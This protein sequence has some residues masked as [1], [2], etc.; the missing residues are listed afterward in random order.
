M[1]IAKKELNIPSLFLLFL[2]FFPL[3]KASVNVIGMG[4]EEITGAWYILLFIIS[5]QLF[6]INYLT[7]LFCE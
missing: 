1:K 3:E 6:T 4:Q 7:I 2:F 5:F